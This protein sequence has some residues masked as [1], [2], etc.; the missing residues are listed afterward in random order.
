MCDEA[1][2]QLWKKR[3]VG[4]QKLRDW[5]EWFVA[6]NSV[7]WGKTKLGV[8]WECVQT[9]L[10]GGYG[11]VGVGASQ[12]GVGRGRVH[13]HKLLIIIKIKII[14]TQIIQF[15]ILILLIIIKKIIIRQIILF[16]L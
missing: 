3:C 9:Q 4:Y 6:I 8:G 12:L 14:V 2:I 15:L 11:R 13:T 16:L 1:N 7:L 10:Q 5:I